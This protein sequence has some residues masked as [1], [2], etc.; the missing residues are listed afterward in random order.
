MIRRPPRSTL[1][2]YTTLFRSRVVEMLS[3]AALDDQ[4]FSNYG[5]ERPHGTVHATNQHLLCALENLARTLALA[6][7]SG[8]RGAHVLSIRSSRLQPACR[9]LGVV[10]KNDFRPRALDARKNLQ[11]NSLFLQ[12][13]LLRRGFDHGVL[14]AD[15]VSTYGNIK[16]I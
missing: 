14:S 5:P 16:R 12:P 11:D 13:T 3:V 9:I 10:G 2:P 1:F 8:L 15:I 4:R 7:Q 6:F